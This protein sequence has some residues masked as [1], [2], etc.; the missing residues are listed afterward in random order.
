MDALENGDPVVDRANSVHSPYFLLETMWQADKLISYGPKAFAD[1]ITTK[2]I[3]LGGISVTDFQ[4]A[5]L[6]LHPEGGFVLETSMFYDDF[7]KGMGSWI[8]NTLAPGEIRHQIGT[9]SPNVANPSGHPNQTAYVFSLGD[10][11]TTPTRLLELDRDFTVSSG[12][13][14]QYKWAHGDFEDNAGH[15]DMDKPDAGED[16]KLY[17]NHN[18]GGWVLAD[19]HAA[20]LATQGDDVGWQLK[21]VI[22]EPLGVAN[23]DTIRIKWEQ[24]AYAQTADN[25]AFADVRVSDLVDPVSPDSVHY[26]NWGEPPIDHTSTIILEENSRKCVSEVQQH[27]YN[28]LKSESEQFIPSYSPGYYSWQKP[29]AGANDGGPGWNDGTNIDLDGGGVIVPATPAPLLTWD[30]LDVGRL[31]DTPTNLDLFTQNTATKPLQNIH[32]GYKI[33]CWKEHHHTHGFTEFFIPPPS[34]KLIEPGSSGYDIRLGGFYFCNDD[35]TRSTVPTSDPDSFDG[36]IGGSWL[37]LRHSETG[38]EIAVTDWVFEVGTHTNKHIVPKG[39]LND[40]T[41]TWVLGRDPDPLEPFDP[42]QRSDGHIYELNIPVLSR[43]GYYDIIIRNYRPWYMQPGAPRQIHMDEI[44]AHRSYYY[45]VD[46]WGGI[47]WGT[48]PW[49]GAES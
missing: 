42:G 22:I 26:P 45:E 40:G 47:A 49:G 11:G 1:L 30:Y 9:L 33:R 32:I 3:P 25:W 27:P 12:L 46:G 10:S 17:Y 16:L 8:T 43:P 4:N 41:Q 44:V 19:T 35:P 23:G 20:T 29:V 5:S 18:N 14:I 39:P 6:N 48:G 24:T 37:F 31:T 2:Y 28:Q 38:D 15:L 7:S 13:I 34:L 36:V 21:N